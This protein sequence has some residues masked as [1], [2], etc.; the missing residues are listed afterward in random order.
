MTSP[1]QALNTRVS[2][3]DFQWSNNELQVDLGE[4]VTWEARHFGVRQL[5]ESE[6]T[7]YQYPVMFEDTMLNGAFKSLRHV[8]SF[9]ETVQGTLMRDNFHY[10][11]PFGICGILAERVFLTRYLTRFIEEKNAHLKRVAESEDWKKYL[12][13]MG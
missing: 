7:A 6:I 10:Q 4:T 3:A 13:L 2:I 8:H 12:G 1:A 9:E 11:A 5:L